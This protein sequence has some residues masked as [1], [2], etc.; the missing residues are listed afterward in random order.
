[1]EI[2]V[3]IPTNREVDYVYTRLRGT[4]LVV[5]M[6]I[7]PAPNYFQVKFHD[8]NNNIDGMMKYTPT[9]RSVTPQDCIITEDTPEVNF[10]VV[11]RSWLT[12]NHFQS[13]KE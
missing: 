6:R 13:G 3:K 10:A 8:T 1:L 9:K 2:P 4:V 5:K 11:N 7:K 12:S